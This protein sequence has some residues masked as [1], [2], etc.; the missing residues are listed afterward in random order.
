MGI[1]M[2]LMV[3]DKEIIISDGK[4]NLP[5]RYEDVTYMGKKQGVVSDYIVLESD[6]YLIEFT[7]NNKKGDLKLAYH[8]RKILFSKVRRTTTTR[9]LE[10]F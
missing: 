3:T 10:A 7:W 5:L 8:T 4:F 9:Q 1:E 6:K 2:L